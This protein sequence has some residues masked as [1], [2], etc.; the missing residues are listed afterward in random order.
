LCSP[1]DTSHGEISGVPGARLGRSVHVPHVADIVVHP[2]LVEDLGQLSAVMGLVNGVL[3]EYLPHRQIENSPGPP[4]DGRVVVQELIV[5]VFDH[6][7]KAAV[8]IPE[9]LHDFREAVEGELHP[10]LEAGMVPQ[11]SVGGFFEHMV[12]V[13]GAADE[14][15]HD[16]LDRTEVRTPV[17]LELRR[18]QFG[19]CPQK[20]LIYSQV[21]GC[22]GRDQVVHGGSIGAFRPGRK[23]RMIDRGS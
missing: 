5:K 9:C 20:L 11:C 13:A 22:V 23:P 21:I 15:C 18:A 4:L 8:E 19:K 16:F 6:V 7:K 12:K 3:Q 17:L 10:I 1:A 14:V 2:K